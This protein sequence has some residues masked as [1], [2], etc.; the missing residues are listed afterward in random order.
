M[1]NTNIT[2]KEYAIVYGLVDPYTHDI[3]YVG[4]SVG[5]IERAHQHWA[6]SSV[7]EGATPKN[8]WINKLR[9]F[10]KKYKVVVLFAIKQNTFSNKEDLNTFIYNK[11]QEFIKMFDK[12]LNLTDGGKGA[13][14]RVTSEQ[15]KHKMS[16]SAKRRGIEHLK[17][18]FFKN[19]SEEEK[20]ITK[21]R[22]AEKLKRR[23]R[24]IPGARFLSSIRHGKK[25]IMK[26]SKGQEIATF[27]TNRWAAS[28][29]GGKCSHTGIRMAIKNKTE[30]YGYFW[31]NV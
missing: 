14:G 8:R 19:K 1:P 29:I 31:E 21:K 9:K 4:K 11:E 3:R 24:K 20:A 25:I 5:G 10:G 22:T 18:H 23:N 6:P 27:F 15:T 7:K 12:L 26:N 16:Q 17:P 28:Y 30:Y 2:Y 13:T